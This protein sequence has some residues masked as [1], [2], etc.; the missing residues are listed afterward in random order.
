MMT[1]SRAPHSHAVAS[2]PEP[3]RRASALAGCG[4]PTRRRAPTQAT[5][6]DGDFPASVAHKFGTT[7]SR[8]RPRRVA[9]YG[10]GDVDTLLALG[11][12]PVL[13]PNIDPRWRDAGGV[14]PWSRAR[15]RGAKPVVAT[16]DEL[17]FERIAAARPDLITAV[18]FDLKR[19][20]YD[21]LRR[22]RRRS[23]RPRALRP[24]PCRGTRWPCRSV[25]PSA[26][27]PTRRGSST[28]RARRS[29]RRPRNPT[30]ASSKAVLVSPDDDGGVYIFA[31]RRRT[32][33]LGPRPDACRPRSRG[34]QG[35]VLRADQRRAA[36]PA[37]HGRRARARRHAQAADPSADVVAQLQGCGGA[38]ERVVPRR[39]PRPRDRDVLLVAAVAAVPAARGRAAPARRAGVS[40]RAAGLALI[41]AGLVL[42][43]LLSISVGARPI[44]LD[45]VWNLV[46][47]PDGSDDAIIVHDLRIPRTMLG[48]LVGAALG[49]GGRAD[50]GADAQ[51]ARRPRA[52]RRQ[53]RRRGRGRHGDRRCSASASPL[54][55][56]WFAFAGAAVAS[57]VVYGARRARAAAARRRCAWRWRA[58]RSRSR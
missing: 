44:A 32:R 40:R 36:R 16:N 13:V 9:T 58:P 35:R 30:F 26:A 2:L 46:V 49:V 53:R 20:D 38:R 7:T 5:A 25:P 8:R 47:A 34:F 22:S 10:G 1:S 15:L 56:V 52:A 28:Q 33:F 19:P 45:R 54:V 21:K 24:T 50:A 23:R 42:V 6:A 3:A 27:R 39:R 55:Y 12:V 37:R 4:A 43:L 41:L 14:A 51:P 17:Q 29:Q 48:L 31:G 11:V 18:E 57:V